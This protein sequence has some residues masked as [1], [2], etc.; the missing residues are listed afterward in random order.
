MPDFWFVFFVG[1]FCVHMHAAI[2]P[3]SKTSDQPQVQVNSATYF[4]LHLAAPSIFWARKAKLVH[5]L[6]AEI[7]NVLYQLALG[8]PLASE[9]PNQVDAGHSGPPAQDHPKA[10]KK[11]TGHPAA[12]EDAT[13]QGPLEL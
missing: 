3:V 13:S 7:Q 6:P 1:P 5:T 11:D 2:F 9:F 8:A 12:S 10:T 4:L